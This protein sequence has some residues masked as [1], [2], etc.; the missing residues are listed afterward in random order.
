M[1]KKQLKELYKEIQTFDQFV[2]VLSDDN[3][4]LSAKK[5]NEKSKKAKRDKAVIATINE[6]LQNNKKNKDDADRN[7]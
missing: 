2:I 4:H 3:A 6:Y 5:I 1:N 7:K